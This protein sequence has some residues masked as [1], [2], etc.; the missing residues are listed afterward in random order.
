MDDL[1][2]LSTSHLDERDAVAVTPGIGAVEGRREVP[3]AVMTA[4]RCR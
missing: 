1:P 3:G 4:V 2:G